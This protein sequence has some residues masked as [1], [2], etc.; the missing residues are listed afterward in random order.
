MAADPEIRKNI[1]RKAGS[2]LARRAYSR[3]ELRAQLA[4]TAAGSELESALDRL[5]QLR[6]LN[7]PEYAY[8]FALS[9]MKRQLWGPARVRE[10]LLGRQIPEEV[11]ETAI[12]RASLE[13]DEPSVLRA[14]LEKYLGGK[15]MPSGPREARKLAMH[16]RR[17]GFGEDNIVSALKQVLPRDT[18]D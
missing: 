11:A 8:N 6:L 17:R 14:Y 9:R 7:D 4:G 1:L 16:L 12:R 5:E 15:G 13:C 2:L 10:A 18:G 3:G